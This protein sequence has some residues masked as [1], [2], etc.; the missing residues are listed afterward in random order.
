MSFMIRKSSL[1]AVLTSALL[2]SVGTAQV[3]EDP[4]PHAIGWEDVSFPD[5]FGG[6]LTGRTY[7]PALIPGENSPPDSLQGPYPVVVFLHG[8]GLYPTDYD[9]VCG[10]AASWGFNVLS[11][12]TDWT[13]AGGTP[14]TDLIQNQASYAADMIAWFEVE[15]ADSQSSY[16]GMI[17]GDPYSA[18]GHSMGGATLSHVIGRVPQIEFLVAL[19]PDGL[20]LDTTALASYGDNVLVVAG[21]E[22]MAVDA[23]PFFTTATGTLRNIW[24][25]LQGA[26]HS[27]AT[28][29]V[30]MN[31][32]MSASDQKRL[33]KRFMT[34]FLRAQVKGEDEL[35]YDL[36][37]ENVSIEPVLQES[38]SDYA[39]F[40]CR[41]SAFFADTLLTGIAP[42]GL[43]LAAFGAGPAPASIPS[44][45]GTIGVQ[46]TGGGLIYS[47][48]VVEADGISELS[49]PIPPNLTGAT[50]WFQ[51]FAAG[52]DSALLTAT[53]SVTLP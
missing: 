7:Y 35:F 50:L 40:W 11:V 20:A 22:D 39:P 12:E 37:G 17:S 8:V 16:F 38:A 28:D 44:P 45:W 2:A 23:Y 19:E 46:L 41:P 18:V 43:D 15:D 33:H 1:C 53:T 29:T 25:E 36:L 6:T 30:P 34:G 52:A 42:T 9:D 51:G 27:G 5:S 10:H 26:G 13:Q 14:Y 49:F 4:G 32:T 3:P 47:T 48:F 21:S 24:S 31:E